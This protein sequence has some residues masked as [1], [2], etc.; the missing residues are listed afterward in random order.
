MKIIITNALEAG[1]PEDM[2]A[3]CEYLL[4]RRITKRHPNPVMGEKVDILYSESDPRMEKEDWGTD[5]YGVY[6]T[7][8]EV[9]MNEIK[10][11]LVY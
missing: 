9:G 6:F 4:E 2:I 1:M 11:N 10:L 3:N 5:A 7:I 8:E